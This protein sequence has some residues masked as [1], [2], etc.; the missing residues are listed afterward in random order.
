MGMRVKERWTNKPVES[1]YELHPVT[2]KICL[3]E[4]KKNYDLS[5]FGVVLPR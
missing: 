5:K 3:Y 2:Y 4:K 1:S